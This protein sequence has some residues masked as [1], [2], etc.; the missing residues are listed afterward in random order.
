MI[1][2]NGKAV[3]AVKVEMAMAT[4]IEEMDHGMDHHDIV[5]DR[6]LV[7]TFFVAYRELNSN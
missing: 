2:D 3:T 4:T 7:S 6:L 1:A 5:I